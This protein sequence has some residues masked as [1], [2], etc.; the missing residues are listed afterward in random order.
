MTAK[1]NLKPFNADCTNLSDRTHEAFVIVTVTQDPLYGPDGFHPTPT[2]TYL[3]A[4]VMYQQISG[5]SPV[6]LPDG[7][8]MPADRALLLQQAAQEANAQFG[9]R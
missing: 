5:R 3:A 6:G 7:W 4:L 8:R 2:A 1:A 9:R